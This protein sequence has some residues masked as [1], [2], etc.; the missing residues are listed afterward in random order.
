M[1]TLGELHRKNKHILAIYLWG[2]IT[3]DEYIEGK[4]DIDA[5]A[6]VDEPVNV[7]ENEVIN[8]SL[9]K[10]VSGLKSILYVSLN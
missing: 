1:I 3:T 10:S 9:N 5:I 6:I 8:E 4:S 7:S 2:S